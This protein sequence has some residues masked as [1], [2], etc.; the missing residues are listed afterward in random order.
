M[1]EAGRNRKKPGSTA[2]IYTLRRRELGPAGLLDNHC[3]SNHCAATI[4]TVNGE[5]NGRR[6]FTLLRPALLGWESL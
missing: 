1:C 2:G 5:V 3:S 4:V 6:V